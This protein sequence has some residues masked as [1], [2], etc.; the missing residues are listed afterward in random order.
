MWTAKSKVPP[1]RTV[2]RIK[3]SCESSANCVFF[4]IAP[5]ARRLCLDKGCG[6][7]IVN[8]GDQ[9]GTSE[10]S[11]ASRFV[12]PECRAWSQVIHRNERDQV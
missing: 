6:C 3:L 5:V 10:L 1:T 7:H 9:S 4:R 2:R 11:V 8:R 12:N